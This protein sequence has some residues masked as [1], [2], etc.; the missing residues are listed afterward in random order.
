MADS[1]P[2][3]TSADGVRRVPTLP[4]R[5]VFAYNEYEHGPTD[6]GRRTAAIKRVSWGA[7]FAGA[8]VAL[9]TGFVLNLLGLGV[10]LQSFDPATEA[11]SVGG[12]GIGQGIWTV[13]SSLAS[14]FAG[15]WVA[16]R[17]AGMPRRTDGMLHGVV[18][19]AVTTV[20]TLYLLTS[21]VGRVVSGVTG[22]LGSGLSAIGSGVA[23]VAPAAADAAQNQLGVDLSDLDVQAIRSEAEQ[24]LRQTG[25]PALQ[26]EALQEQADAVAANAP[27]DVADADVQAAIDRTYGRAEGVVREVDREDLVNVLAARTD[28]SE[29]EARQ[30]VTNWEAQFRQTRQTVSREVDSLQTQAVSAAESATD[31]L[32]TAALVGFFALLLG[33]ISAGF[34]GGVGSPHDLPAGA[35]RRDED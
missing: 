23:A 34:G 22:L 9:V 1:V 19:W 29:A 8:L 4:D 17:L 28:M 6:Y 11:D 35:F 2:T 18:V 10:G 24:L 16:G 26:P 15:G 21:G 12:F 20:F 30:T 25:D 13:I 32:G 3:T 7:I 5:D 31:F 27:D 33:A 14:L